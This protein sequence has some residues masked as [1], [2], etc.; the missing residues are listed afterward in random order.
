MGKTMTSIPTFVEVFQDAREYL[1]FFVGQ[2]DSL[3]VCL[4]ERSSAGRRKV[5]R[6]AED[7]LVGRKKPSLLPHLRQLSWVS[8]RGAVHVTEGRGSD[9]KDDPP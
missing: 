4:E 6:H 2:V 1:G 8:T 3:G 7:I 9:E 5:R